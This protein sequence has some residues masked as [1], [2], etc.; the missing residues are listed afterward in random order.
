[1][2]IGFT[3]RSRSIGGTLRQRCVYSS[4]ADA[5][6]CGPQAPRR[7]SFY[8]PNTRTIYMN[9]QTYAAA[10][11]WAGYAGLYTTLAHEW[12]HHVQFMLRVTYGWPN[13]ECK[14]IVAPACSWQAAGPPCHRLTY[15]PCGACLPTLRVTHYT[16]VHRNDSLPSTTGY[17][18]GVSMH[19]GLP[20]GYP[21][22]G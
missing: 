6:P 3:S 14:L 4:R 20:L 17:L 11:T 7:T 15:K 16:A 1:M 19:C 2:S 12:T 18:R 8:C 21:Q 5:I 10:S 9:Q 13:Y 22:S